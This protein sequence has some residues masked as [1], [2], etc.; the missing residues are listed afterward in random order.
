MSDKDKE[1]LQDLFYRN[2]MNLDKEKIIVSRKTI[3]AYAHCV[4]T[5]TVKEILEIQSNSNFEIEEDYIKA[6][7]LIYN[8]LSIHH[9][10]ILPVQ[11]I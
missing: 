11:L 2:G 9:E 1:D 6:Q 8:N 10:K 3:S 5:A 7:E 4:P